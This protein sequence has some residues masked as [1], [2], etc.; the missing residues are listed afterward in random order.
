MGDRAV[1]RLTSMTLARLRTTPSQVI[2]N[3]K[4]VD[5]QLTITAT[6]AANLTSPVRMATKLTCWEKAQTTN[7]IDL[8]LLTNS[9]L[10]TFCGSGQKFPLTAQ[11]LLVLA[12]I[13]QLTSRE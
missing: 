13:R 7:S 10:G 12:S 2:M 9:H 5:N 11:V 3:I 1:D 4:I 6:I 8:H